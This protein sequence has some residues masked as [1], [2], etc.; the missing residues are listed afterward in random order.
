MPRKALNNNGLGDLYRETEFGYDKYNPEDRELEDALE[1]SISNDILKGYTK[2]RNN[3]VE[4][5]KQQKPYENKVHRESEEY[6]KFIAELEDE[7]VMQDGKH[8]VCLTCWA[9]L[10]F[11]KKR[12]HEGMGHQCLQNSTCCSESSF[13]HYAQLFGKISDNEKFITLFTPFEML[14]FPRTDNE[15]YA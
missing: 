14:Q 12:W 7:K 11:Y 5:N 1:E 3:F 9:F 8:H 6:R 4:P 10:T 15:L 13:L 2:D